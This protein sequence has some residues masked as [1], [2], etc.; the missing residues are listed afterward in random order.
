MGGLFAMPFNSKQTTE[1]LREAASKKSTFITFALFGS[2]GKRRT[3]RPPATDATAG[4]T[5]HL[6]ST[7]NRNDLTSFRVG[8]TSGWGSSTRQR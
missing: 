6:P 4:F 7:V 2:S 1:S 3:L 5:A 8:W